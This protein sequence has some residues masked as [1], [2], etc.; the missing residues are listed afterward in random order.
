MSLREISGG[1]LAALITG[2]GNRAQ[3]DTPPNMVPYPVLNH[4]NVL[5]RGD[6]VMTEIPI[7]D[8]IVFTSCQFTGNISLSRTPTAGLVLDDCTVDG[9][10]N[11]A[12]ATALTWLKLG[13]LNADKAYAPTVFLPAPTQNL[14]IECCDSRVHLVIRH[15]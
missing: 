14:R 1:R 3:G 2:E 9:Q 7:N 12:G 13:R 10:I 8:P 5:V 6:L 11:L 15:I 4:R